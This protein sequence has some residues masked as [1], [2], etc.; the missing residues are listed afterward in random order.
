MSIA[1]S[2]ART[3]GRF[4]PTAAAD[5]RNRRCAQA[6]DAAEGAVDAVELGVALL[7][8]RVLGDTG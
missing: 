3:T 7:L 6:P 4:T 1:A 5:R 8:D 2:A